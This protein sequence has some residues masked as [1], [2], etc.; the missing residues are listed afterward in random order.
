MFYIMCSVFGQ[1]TCVSYALI[2]DDFFE[3]FLFNLGEVR[4]IVILSSDFL[5]FRKSVVN[6]S[7]MRAVSRNYKGGDVFFVSD[8][9]LVSTN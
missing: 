4:D 1:C 9:R 5:L 7:F 2:F 3:I 8:Y 6:K